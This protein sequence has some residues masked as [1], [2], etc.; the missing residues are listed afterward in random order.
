MSDIGTMKPVD[1][2]CFIGNLGNG[3][4]GPEPFAGPQCRVQDELAL[5][6]FEAT[7]RWL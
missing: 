1:G 3:G 4:I 6:G 2:G 7:A 5:L